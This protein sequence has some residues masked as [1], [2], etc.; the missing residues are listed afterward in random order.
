M[1]FRRK[2]VFKKKQKLIRVVYVCEVSANKLSPSCRQKT[3]SGE[4]SCCCNM[5]VMILYWAANTNETVDQLLF[6]KEKA[7]GRSI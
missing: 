4:S 1:A 3:E 5:S 6:I 7:Y 2:N